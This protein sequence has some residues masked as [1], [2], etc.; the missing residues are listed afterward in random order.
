M[1][2]DRLSNKSCY[3]PCEPSTPTP[4]AAPLP[5]G[6]PIDWV[7]R[8]FEVQSILERRS[9]QAIQLAKETPQAVTIANANGPEYEW[10]TRNDP[11]Y[12]AFAKLANV[13]PSKVNVFDA[14]SLDIINTRHDT[15]LLVCYCSKGNTGWDWE[16]HLDTREVYFVNDNADL[17]KKYGLTQ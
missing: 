3:M 6:T 14:I 9:E 1:R 15:P 11:Q 16:V 5:T 7:Q 13:Q 8:Y 2:I 12:R 17:S 4:S 10:T